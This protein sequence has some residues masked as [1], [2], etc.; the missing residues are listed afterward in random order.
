MALNKKTFRTRTLTA[1]IFIIVMLCGLLINQW[2]FYSLFFIIHWGCWI[3]YEKLI[4]LIS[5][6]YAKA[7]LRTTSLP[8]LVGCGFLIYCLPHDFKI[9]NFNIYFLGEMIMLIG[10]IKFILGTFKENENKIAIIKYASLGLLYI[11]LSW[12]LM[13]NLRNI[14]FIVFPIGFVAAITLV[15]SVW[16][17]DTMQYIVGS[18]IGKTPF[19]KISPNK[20]L[21]GTIG[22]SILCVVAVSLI[23]YFLVN[24]NLLNLFIIVS[25]IAAVIGTLGDLL[26]SK[27]KRLAGVKDSGN[28]M[29]GHGGFLDRFDSLILAAPFVWVVVLFWFN[30]S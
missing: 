27:I 30:I 15:G 25:L 7:D 8:K 4:K 22:G 10:G 20:T 12:G 6:E 17:N 24:K 11:S 18:L 21:E 1:L 26:E 14:H 28:F 5:P 23:G 16:V 13:I 3:E 9:L 2:S 19:S 29:P